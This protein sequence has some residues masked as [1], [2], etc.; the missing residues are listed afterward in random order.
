MTIPN[1][2][3][4]TRL[5]APSFSLYRFVVSKTSGPEYISPFLLERPGPTAGPQHRRCRCRILL[6][7]GR[8]AAAPAPLS[9]GLPL[10]PRERAGSGAITDLRQGTGTTAGAAG[11][12]DA[13][14]AA[15]GVRDSDD[16]EPRC[17]AAQPRPGQRRP[18]DAMVASARR[19]AAHPRPGRR[20]RGC[21][22]MA[23]AA[24]CPG[25]WS[26]KGGASRTG[27]QL[28]WSSVAS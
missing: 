10:M 11:P 18:T 17:R 14:P 24:Q 6:A 16:G 12:A 23:S 3:S 21:V 1:D 22:M 26:R 4:C 2:S 13:A 9:A 19:P 20:R 5:L 28:Q 15:T 27:S 25:S 7:P 8:R